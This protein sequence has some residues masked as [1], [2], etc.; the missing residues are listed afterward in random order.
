MGMAEVLAQRRARTAWDAPGAAGAREGPPEERYLLQRLR[1]GDG[2]ALAL[3][4]DRWV[5]TVHALALGMLGSHADAEDVCQEVFLRLHRARGRVRE[6][7]PLR[8][9]LGRTC[10]HCCLDARRARTRRRFTGSAAMTASGGSTSGLPSVKS[11]TFSAPRSRRRRMPSS[12][13]RRIQD[14]RS[15]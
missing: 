5:G 3:I 14:A 1:Q 11:K 8:L 12:N 6:D 13:M 9:W 7:M 15:S 2:E 4:M 10:V